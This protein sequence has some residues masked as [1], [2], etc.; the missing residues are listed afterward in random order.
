MAR[1]NDEF[2]ENPEWTEEMFK[3]A[4]HAS[5]I[6]A[7]A[8]LVRKGRGPQKKPTKRATTIRLSPEVLSFFQSR[9]D[10]WQARIDEALK[11]YVKQHQKAS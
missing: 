9:G 8:D 11:E 3:T 7:L 10:G 5:E 1:K 4:K 6:P 2:E